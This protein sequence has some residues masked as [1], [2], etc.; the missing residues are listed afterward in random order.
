[1]DL[2]SKREFLDI[3][4]LPGEPE[5]LVQLLKFFPAHIRE[6]MSQNLLAGAIEEQN[7][8]R[9]VRGDQAATHGMDNVL[10]EI[11]EAQKFF[12]FFLE[13]LP[14][15]PKRVD[16][17]AG[18]I[19]NCQETQEIHN[20]PGAQVLDRRQRRGCARQFPRIGQKS[21]GS[22]ERETDG[23]VEER[24]A[25]GKNDAAY[26]NDQQIKRD[27]IA[28]L[29]TSQ[30]NQQG[31]HHD[32]AGHLHA[33]VPGCPGQPPEQDK[34]KDS[35]RDPEDDQGE[36]KP[37]GA[38]TRH[39]LRPHNTHRQNERDREQ[40]DTRQP[41]QPSFCRKTLVH[42]FPAPSASHQGIPK[43][44]QENRGRRVAPRPLERLSTRGRS[45]A[46]GWPAS[47]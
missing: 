33:A 29:R 16:K 11:L 25:T 24:D 6:P 20:Q 13:F 22:E 18:Q 12:A 5:I 39:I 44:R 27:E 28:L 15:A 26:D 10:R 21:Q 31:H 46:S 40:P 17:Q 19:G 47:R 43:S 41:F 37:V 23:G 42:D 3:R 45:A 14:L 1:M 9:K 7:N 34:V 35:D 30:V 2:F 4:I 32:V 36:K 38:Q 8:S